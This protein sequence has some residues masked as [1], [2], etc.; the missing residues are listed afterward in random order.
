MNRDVKS[1][2][3]A[4]FLNGECSHDDVLVTNISSLS[5]AKSDS[6]SFYSDS[7]FKNDLIN[8]KAGI[9]I[10]KKS[11]ANLFNGPSIYV[12]NPYV[13]YAKTSAFF[14]KIEA[15]NEIHP[16][17][18]I[19]PSTKIGKNIG[20]GPFS[21]IGRNCIIGD[22]TVIG[23]NVTIEDNVS[24]GKNVKLHSNVYIGAQTEIGDNCE[25]FSGAKI[26]NDGF[27]YAKD[28][29]KTW[30][31]IP[32]I[33]SVKIGNNVDIGANSTIDRGAIDKTIIDNGVKIDNLVQIGHNCKIGENTIIAGCAGIAGSTI[34]GK[35]C[36][37]GGAAM[38]KGH[39]SIADDT[40]ISG[41][42]GMGK[43]V[44]S[45]GKRFTNV[46]PYNIEHKDWLRIANNLKKI[47]KKND[48]TFNGY[49]SNL[50]AL[51]A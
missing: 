5:S 3:I 36:M 47:G 22:N 42:T 31:K 27:G 32:Q 9:V 19:G 28:I 40:I 34:I 6:I 25:F 16:S 45:A 20:L 12:D 18:L 37:I 38:I 48:W 21:I 30:V 2:F 15:K 4:N 41:G 7:K 14:N 39:I 43:N 1:S 17:S 26:G 33:G 10:L 29:D 13:A 35:N 50:R 24:I 11:D 49:P 44:E 8:T 51:A 46:F 23:S